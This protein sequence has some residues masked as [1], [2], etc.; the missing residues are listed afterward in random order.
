MNDDHPS[1]APD[2]RAACVVMFGFNIAWIF[3]VIWAVWGLVYVV[4]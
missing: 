3:V 4:L 1:P 2:F